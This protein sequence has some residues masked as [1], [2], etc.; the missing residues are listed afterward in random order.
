MNGAR[1]QHRLPEVLIRQ[2]MGILVVAIGA[3]YPATSIHLGI[4]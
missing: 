2:V 4:P 1:V 3:H